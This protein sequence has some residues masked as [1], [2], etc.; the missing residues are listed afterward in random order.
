MEWTQR[1]PTRLLCF[2]GRR[3]EFCCGGMIG[4]A[5]IVRDLGVSDSCRALRAESIQTPGEMHQLRFTLNNIPAQGE[6]F[7]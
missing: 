1:K 6:D 5:E 4:G 7:T 2:A 3:D